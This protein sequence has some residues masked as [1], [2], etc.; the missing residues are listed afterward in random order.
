MNKFVAALA[1][2]ASVII[3]VAVGRSVHAHG[4]SIAG[5]ASTAGPFL[6][7]A[8]VG[9]LAV[10]G[11]TRPNALWPTGISVWIATVSIGQIL[12]LVIGQGSAIAFVLVS[13]GFFAI[14]MLGWRAV[15]VVARSVFPR[16]AASGPVR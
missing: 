16:D 2:L 10:H 3:F 9:W 7:G 8:V 4:D 11:W 12:R 6:A 1:D 15:L 14:T 5:I 13:L